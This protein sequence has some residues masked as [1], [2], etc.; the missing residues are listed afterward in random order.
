MARKLGAADL[1]EEGQLQGACQLKMLSAA[2]VDDPTGT[3]RR[4]FTYMYTVA[5]ELRE[6]AALLPFSTASYSHIR[7]VEVSE[8][9]DR[10]D[11]RDA[12]ALFPQANPFEICIRGLC[13][14]SAVALLRDGWAGF[15]GTEQDRA[16]VHKQGR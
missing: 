2:A 4:E 14:R 16:D 5:V 10:W 3:G 9:M 8:L 7:W 11:H 1:L 13:I 12:L 15:E 6:G